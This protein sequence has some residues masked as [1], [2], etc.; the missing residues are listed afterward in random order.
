MFKW[1][2]AGDDDERN[3]HKL[4][5]CLDSDTVQRLVRERGFSIFQTLM[6]KVDGFGSGY[7]W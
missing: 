1:S 4:I 2:L 6:M 7:S 3:D 5:Y